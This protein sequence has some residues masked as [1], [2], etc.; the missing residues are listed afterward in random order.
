MFVSAAIWA[1]I[2]HDGPGLRVAALFF[3]INLVFFG[4]WFKSIIATLGKADKLHETLIQLHSL[5]A[6]AS[7]APFQASHLQSL[8]H[9]EHAEVLAQLAKQ[10]EKLSS[11]QNFLVAALFNGVALYHVRAYFQ[12]INFQ[13]KNKLHLQLAL[14]S[15]AELE[16]L[17]SLSN[18]A[19]NFPEHAFPELNNERKISFNNLKHPLLSPKKAVGNSISFE[20]H[21]FVILTGSNMSGKST[22][23]RALGINMVLANCGSC[24]AA[25]AASVHPMDV[26]VSMRLDDSLEDSTSYFYAETLRLQSVMHHLTQRDA[27]VLLDEILRGTN[28]DDKR[29]GTIA[30]IEQLVNRKAIGAIATHDLEVCAITSLY[31]DALSNKCFEVQISGNEMT[32]DYTLREGICQNKS[33]SFIM[34]KLG[35]LGRG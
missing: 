2:Q 32:F 3:V 1:N 29:E 33:A 6:M 31:P 19:Y 4:L 34:H 22:F 14:D 26:L 21:P 12:L 35:I 7:N 18:Y 28:S 8:Q 24:V 30:V 15:I 17:S 5:S 10:F 13:R 25:S 23:L 20:E 16:A 27:F 11:V 9:P